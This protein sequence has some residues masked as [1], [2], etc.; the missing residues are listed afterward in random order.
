MPLSKRFATCLLVT[1]STFAQAQSFV[2][3]DVKPARSV[4]LESRRVRTLPNG[5]LIGT[6]VNAITLISEGYSVP[7]NPS[8]RLSTL[9]PWVYSERYDIEAKA[10]SGA[11]Q[12]SL[13]GNASK[14]VRDMFR[15]ILADRFHLVM[16]AENRTVP[17]YA[18]VV[19]RG[20]P[21]MKQSN[22]SNCIFD[23][24]HDGCHSFLIGFGHPL[25]ARAVDMDDLAHYI[26]NWN[27]FA[28]CQQN[29]AHRCLHNQHRGL[30]ADAA[31]PSTAQWCRKRGLHTL[32]DDRYGPQRSWT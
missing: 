15:Q 25:N 31:A 13:D 7:A 17:V 1:A 29:L 6:S 18:L 12:M 28:G 19:A 26:E 16:R 2:A 9:P 21:K 30:A 22:V 8:D 11:K 24:A 10:S 32:A 23:T 4:D 3:I 5:D 27:R 20:G 14:P